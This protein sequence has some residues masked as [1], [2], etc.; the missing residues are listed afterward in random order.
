MLKTQRIVKEIIVE[1]DESSW[2][3]FDG[4]R[5]FSQTWYAPVK[6][7]AVINLIHGLSDHSSRYDMWARRL[8]QAGFTVRSF[9]LR[10]HG[11]SE[12]KRGYCKDYSV[13]I[14]DIDDFIRKGKDLF[15]DL[16]FF[17]Y[18][19]SMGGNLLINYAIRNHHFNADGLII[20]SPWL[21]LVKQQSK[22]KVIA[23]SIVGEILPGLMVNNDLRP[24]DISR[25][26]RV[27]HNYRTD[28]YSFNKINIRFALQTI[29]AGHKASI[30]I[31]KINV[32]LLVMHGSD[33][34][35]TSCKASKNFVRNAG[36]RTTFIEWQG[37]YHELHND[38]DRDKVFEALV[39]WLNRHSVNKN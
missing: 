27:V 10:G 11:R 3:S 13:M 8:A 28:K 35:I 12:G 6:Q 26:L 24:E 32:P 7:K 23:A 15:P 17:F 16:P 37:C 4:L 1:H 2:K 21:E 29:E 14:T 31:Y 36:Q 38:I 19:H 5:L 20:T 25:D 18:G 39:L 34:R 33:D 9:D 22:T 30:S